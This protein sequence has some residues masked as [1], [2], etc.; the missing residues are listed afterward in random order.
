MV[1]HNS[2]ALNYAIMSK[3][4]IILIWL[5][6]FVLRLSKYSTMKKLVNDLDCN[7]IN[8]FQDLEQ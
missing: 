3:I 8:E 5:D 1:T 4:P 7:L 6:E 2:T